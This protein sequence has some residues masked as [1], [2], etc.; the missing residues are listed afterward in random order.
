MSTTTLSRTEPVAQ[1]TSQIVSAERIEI[2]GRHSIRFGLVAVLAWI[3][4]MKFTAY[5]A[6]GISGLVS[7]SPMMAWVYQVLSVRQFGVLLGVVEILIAGLIATRPFSAKVSAAG[8]ALA[9]GMFA[10]TLSFL[11][12]TPGVVE[13]SL[14]FPALSVMP[15]QFLIKDIVLLATAIWATGKALNASKQNIGN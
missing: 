3:G 12:T 11:F 5:E 15:G 1:S 9:V 13:S 4:A 10:T 2:V 7:N 6:E 14:G 8:S